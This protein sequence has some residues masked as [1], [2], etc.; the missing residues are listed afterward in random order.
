VVVL[1]GL[2]VLW[3]Y[4]LAPGAAGKTP[5]GWPAGT[6]LQLHRE[7]HT[8]VMFVH[9][10]C[11]SSRASIG[12]LAIAMARTQKHLAAS[13]LFVKPQGF[14]D[15]WATT[16]LW[17]TAASI[18]GVEVRVD[19]DGIETRR[20]GAATSGHAILYAPDG[21]RLFAGGITA[22]RGHSGDNAGRA[23]LVSLVNTGSY[24]RKETFVYGCPLFDEAE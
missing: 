3:N 8:L 12:E 22:S 4:N 2:A 23:A 14:A 10:H 17:R 16:D 24:E 13:V 11:P 18:P 9:P 19:G 6:L 7:Q 21:Q 5:S 15:E 20:F 1:L